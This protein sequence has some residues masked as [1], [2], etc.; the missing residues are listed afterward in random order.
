MET[1]N[2]VKSLFGIFA[3]LFLVSVASAATLNLV[4]TNVP[5]SVNPGEDVVITFDLVHD[6]VNDQTG[7][8]W[9]GSSVTKGV[10]KQL[11]ILTS[12]N[13]GE[14]KSLSAT[15]TANE[16]AAGNL[17]F[18]INVE[19]DTNAMASLS[20]SIAINNIPGM[21]LSVKTPLTATQN[22]IIVVENTG[23]TALS[24]I[25]LTS[26]GEFDVNFDSN[27]FNLN[28]G[29][30]KEVIVSIVELGSVGFE[31]KSV[32]IKAEADDLTNDSIS[33]NVPGSFC[34]SGPAGEDLS[35]NR[36]KIDNNGEGKD[37]EWQLLDEIEVEVRVDNDGDENIDDVFVEL[38]LFDS[39][40]R[41]VV[42]D[43][44]FDNTDEEEI[45]VGRIGDNSDETVTFTFKVPADFDDGSYS[46]TVK[47]YSDDLGESNEC[48]DSSN[49]LSDDTFEKIDV[50]RES[51]EGK[52]ISFEDTILTP[53]EAVCGERVLL[54]TDM[55]NIGDED[56]D[57]V[58]VNLF[59]SEL[60]VN[61][62][63]EIRNDLDQ[64]D[65]ES[66]TF[67]FLVPTNAKDKNY[68]LALSSD[69]DYKSGSYRE[70]SDEDT[71][72]LL[73]VIGCGTDTGTDT[74]TGSSGNFA[75]VS[76]VLDSDAKA[77][78]SLV[79]RANVAN[80]KSEQGSFIIS[81]SGYESWGELDDISQRIITL[82]SG[83][84]KEVLLTFLVDAD[85]TGSNSFIIEVRDG[86][87]VITREVVVNIEPSVAPGVTGFASGIG[88][89]G[90][91]LIW[92]IAVIN[93]I[94]IVLIIIVA[95]RVARR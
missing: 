14:T 44:E 75:S 40:G 15:I 82:D 17:D 61:E 21:E 4:A 5:D 54:T 23:N 36:V 68:A 7:L 66:L 28:S 41:N 71:V 53:S 16:N 94:L 32:S 30:K 43:L 34:K 38:G 62:V 52:F 39:A 79:V 58:R 85:T 56:Q 31:G 27:N 10:Y 63:I 35:I 46:L 22:G 11:P 48:D 64:G 37:D 57:Q 1:K 89:G 87:D 18:T 73:K 49:D 83:D 47:A 78:E 92:V 60:G 55:F 20:D 69:Y 76:A 26:S 6:G 91:S 9:S 42:G 67:D 24:G 86:S 74:G 77:G 93:V 8:D 81:A 29:S 19:S 12:L 25:E 13:I 3:V 95:I 2:L 50:E 88:L 84:N 72:V 51:D 33:L 45:D 65:K 80:L 59:N 90:N 70:S